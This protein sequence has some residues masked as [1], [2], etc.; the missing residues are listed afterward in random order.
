MLFTQSDETAIEKWVGLTRR[1][2]AIERQRHY[3]DT[4]LIRHVYDLNA[5]KKADRINPV[6]FD[7]ARVIVS[8]DAKQFKNQH[9]EYFSNPAT[10]IQQSIKILKNKEIWRD[11]YDRFSNSMVYDKTT[12]PDYSNAIESLE[13][14]SNNIIENLK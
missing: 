6:F 7:L 2:A 12:L 10:E 8:A 4:T 5:L 11:R 1:I 14:I 3:D 13:N 9:P